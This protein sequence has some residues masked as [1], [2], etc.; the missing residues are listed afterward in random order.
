LNPLGRGLL[1]ITDRSP[2]RRL[3]AE[4][5][6]GRRVSHRFVAGETLDEGAA[7]ARELNDA[8]FPVSLDHL[9]EHVDS[10]EACF[11][12]RDAYLTCLDRIGSDG[13]HANIS[14]KLSQLG[15]GFDE[16]LATD[17]L[18]RLVER[19]GEVG[20]TVTVDMEE[21]EYVEGTIT[22]YEAVQASGKNAGIAVQSYLYRTGPDLDRIIPLG[23]HVRLC[24]GAYAEPEEV[25]YQSRA[26]VDTSFDRLAKRL[27]GVAGLVP[28]IATHDTARIEQTKRLAKTREAPWEF[29]MLYG[30][31][32]DLQAELVDDGYQVRV[33][34]PY[35]RAWYPY[36]T[37]RMAERPANLAF[38]VRAVAGK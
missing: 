3:F 13:L 8:G 9:G 32:R 34:L 25:A 19:A 30:V 16:E 36:L 6:A 11:A 7:V 37:R 18:G 15:L 38:F 1:A 20:T 26:K 2:V 21:S 33:Y 12:A 17:S 23:G 22:A 31:R 24:K 28:A 29:Q 5:A 35:G 4:T 27:M 14:V 10:F